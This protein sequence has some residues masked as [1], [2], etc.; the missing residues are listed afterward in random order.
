[1]FDNRWKPYVP[2]AKR[3]RNAAT[4]A[5]KLAKKGQSVSPVVIDGAKI[6]K[7]FW[8]KAWCENLERY[9]DYSNRL[10][11]GR[12]YLRNGFVVDLQIEPGRVTALVS[13][14]RVYRIEVKV[15]ALS[16]AR[17]TAVCRDC[18]GAID[19]V[20]ELLEGRLSKAVMTRVCDQKTG[21]FPT[22]AEIGFKCSCPDWALMCKHVAAVLYGI[23]ARLDE[24]PELLFT[25]RLV[26]Q[27]DLIARAG[28]GI[29]GAR[30]LPSGAKRLEAEDLSDIFGIEIAELPSKPRKRVRPD[31]KK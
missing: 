27:H 22:P 13:G 14:S 1:V 7:T 4:E 6:A 8:G 17:W 15:S 9:S 30:K 25:L 2:A 29:S 16:K 3:R 28:E 10:P 19:S 23:G 21:L 5:A 26:D 31:N 18:A 11:R 12:T 20:V 24:R